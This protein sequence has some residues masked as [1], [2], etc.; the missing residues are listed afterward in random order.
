MNVSSGGLAGASARRS[1]IIPIP[2]NDLIDHVLLDTLLFLTL[3]MDL[4]HLW[5]SHVFTIHYP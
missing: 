4:N 3:R 1:F 5:V 2:G